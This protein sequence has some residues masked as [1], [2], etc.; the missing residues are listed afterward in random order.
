MV[1]FGYKLMSEEHAPTALVRNVVRAEKAGFEFAAISDHYSP[2]LEEQGHSSFAWTVLGAAAQATHRIGLMTA[3][4]CPTVRYH[5]AIIAQAAATVALLSENRFTL[6]LGAGERLN[7]HIVGEGWPGIHERHERLSEAV[8]IIQQLF[9]GDVVNHDGFFY[10]IDHARLFDRP[11]QAPPIVIAAG[12]EKAVRLAA[13]SGAALIATE[14]NEAL[15]TAY[16]DAGGAGPR[17]AE[18]GMCHGPSDEAARE[19]AHKYFRWSLTGWPVMAELPSTDAFA[20]ASKH[21]KPEDV[22]QQIPCGPR[23]EPYLAAI[24]KFIDAGFDHLI[25]TQIGPDQEPFIEFFERELAPKLPGSS[26]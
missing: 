1:A 16:T 15:V 12:G 21:I 9:G 5:P 17:Y 23:I 14:P 6:G 19:T 22:A 3:V 2:W 20:A 13:E 4:T 8:E 10:T 18:I 26:R 24:E 25:L 7:E 11:D